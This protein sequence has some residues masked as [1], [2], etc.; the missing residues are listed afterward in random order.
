[1]VYGY[2]LTNEERKTVKKGSYTSSTFKKNFDENYG[3]SLLLL[4]T[5]EKIPMI[6]FSED[7]IKYY[8]T[9]IDKLKFLGKNDRK[10]KLKENLEKI[11]REQVIIA[12]VS[13]WECYFLDVSENI[14]IDYILEKIYKDKNKL[15]KFLSDFNLRQDFNNEMLSNGYRIKGLEFADFIKKNKKINFQDID[16]LKNFLNI[17]YEINIVSID[18]KNWTGIVDLIQDRHKIIHNK[19]D[20]LQYDKIM[21]KYTIEKIKN[22]IENMKKIIDEIDNILFTHYEKLFQI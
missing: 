17:L 11:V 7:D 5:A 16:K 22:I 4:A 18:E 2:C 1:M 10:L 20:K 6:D 19:N 9:L 12:G 14:L 3:N 15:K 21:N 8:E 13:N